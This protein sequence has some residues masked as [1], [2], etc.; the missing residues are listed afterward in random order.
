MLK[1]NSYQIE[2]REDNMDTNIF[3]Q[4]LLIVAQC[5][6][7][8]EKY[9]EKKHVN[10]SNW[11]TQVI[12]NDSISYPFTVFFTLKDN[13]PK[14]FDMA[15]DFAPVKSHRECPGYLNNMKYGKFKNPQLSALSFLGYLICGMYLGKLPAIINSGRGLIAETM[16]KELNLIDLKVVIHEY[17]TGGRDVPPHDIDLT[18]PEIKALLKFFIVRSQ[19][20]TSLPEKTGADVGNHESGVTSLDG[21]EIVDVE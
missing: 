14:K 13:K 1:L 21:V 4:S 2:K 3:L 7:R 15:K 12:G 9:I 19:R 6:T 16:I 18:F 10:V 11:V 8:L 17:S 5:I 20:I